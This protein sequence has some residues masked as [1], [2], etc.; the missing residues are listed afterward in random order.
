MKEQELRCPDEGGGNLPWWVSRLRGLQCWV[1]NG[2]GALPA[3]TWWRM[4]LPTGPW[5]P[6]WGACWAWQGLSPGQP[7]IL[8]WS[9]QGTASWAAP[10][11]ATLG[12]S[13]WNTHVGHVFSVLLSSEQWKWWFCLR[14][15]KRKSQVWTQCLRNWSCFCLCW[16]CSNN[17]YSFV[18]FSF[19]RN[20][21]VR[22][23]QINVFP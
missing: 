14:R 21:W 5:I 22:Q 10:S 12:I 6:A 23:F 8:V 4:G 17:I 1:I 2:T 16:I 3:R 13:E 20:V 18:I 9:Q 7:A 19:Q 11:T 15:E